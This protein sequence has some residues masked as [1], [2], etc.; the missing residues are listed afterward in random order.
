MPRSFMKFP[1]VVLALSILFSC[2]G[3]PKKPA[4]PEKTS[5]MEV[6]KGATTSDLPE[7]MATAE[8]AA[9]DRPMDLQPY[10]DKMMAEGRAGPEVA[11]PPPGPVMP[12][13]AP[14]DEV[15]AKPVEPG[16]YEE[17]PPAEPESEVDARMRALAEQKTLEMQAKEALLDYYLDRAESNLAELRYD[18]AEADVR[19]ALEIAPDD[20]RAR[21]LFMEIMAAQ[22][23]R[24]ETVGDAARTLAEAHQVRQQ[25]AQTKAN[26]YFQ[27]GVK[28]FSEERYPTAIENF[29]NVL[30]I[31]DRG[32]YGVDWGTLRS[33]TEE[34]LFRAR[35]RLATAQQ[36][37]AREA[38]RRALT[39]VREIELREREEQ[40]ARINRLLEEGL[41]AFEEDRFELAENLAEQV[42]ELEPSNARA[43]ELLEQSLRAKHR[44]TDE[45]QLASVKE[46]FRAWRLD[47]QETMIPWSER[48]LIWPSQREWDRVN[49]RSSGLTDFG[50]ATQ[51][52]PADQALKNRL[53]EETTE[54]NFPGV[55]LSEALEFLRQLH[56]LNIIVDDEVLAD[57]EGATVTMNVQGLELAS[58]LDI[59]LDWG[60]AEL[61]Y[62][63]RN[64]T[65]VITNTA[66]ARGEAVL[67][68]HPVGDLTTKLTNFIAP[69]LV[70]KPAG[71]DISDD[72]PQF[73][74]SEEGEVA[75]GGDASE[76][77]DLI[78][79]NLDPD[80][81]AD[82]SISVS[83]EDT[84]VVNHTPEM[85][86]RIA[87]FLNDLRRF[88]GLVVTIEARF[89]EVN[90][91]F[92][93][94]IGVD[95][96][97]LGGERGTLASLDDVTNGLE[98]N[99]SAGFDNQGGGTSP[100]PA[101]G[102][103]S[104]GVFFNDG[105]D[106][107]Y[108]G[109]TEGL[110]DRALGQ[111]L[112]PVGGAV[113]QFTYLDDTDVGLILKAVEKSRHARLLQAPSITVYNT[114]RANITL[115]NQLSFIQDFDVEVAQTAFIA[116]PL[117]SI[118]QDGMTL[119]VRPTISHDRRYVTLELQPTIA[120]LIRPIQT[121]T[122]SLGAGTTPV[123]LQLPETSIQKSQTTVKVPD[124]GSLVIGGL[125]NIS[126]ADLESEVPFLSKIPIL[127][128][129]FSRRGTSKEVSNLI[130]IVTARITDMH[131][132]E[133]MY[134]RPYVR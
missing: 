134:R 94:D 107:D 78:T 20:Q 106:G 127:N 128:F 1:L 104:S 54:F 52:S 31:I 21:D 62:V 83:G 111:V 64:R 33:E 11:G 59:L 7:E 22:G 40:E 15:A 103:P 36:E 56:G 125:K 30:T 23:R 93:Q 100:A 96:R 74:G 50:A 9:P 102:S 65:I 105:G 35:E 12:P 98:D 68:V 95:I 91:D 72:Q 24:G 2:G 73:G 6:A 71:A 85:Q 38:A 45:R 81:W 87:N 109:R 79:A 51:L 19:R 47:I 3:P 44:Q 60:G 58:A 115:V 84:L 82:Y 108:R 43:R 117:V 18:D 46:D 55:S 41:E 76:L 53:A 28:A 110:F 57:V 118:I 86:E 16:K 49:R 131:E 80:S 14:P 27:E 34:F 101:S 112:S 90:D 77:M 4:P 99:A 122:V 69:N 116:D 133:M 32:P 120:T 70:L 17:T 66:G 114:Q 130:V 25:E 37:A 5:E 67:R 26:Y 75:V 126:F 10:I 29:E 113:I 124:G 61:T 48:P 63:V 129:L 132:E 13:V 97:G 39:E 8:P 123:T 42:L 92:L 88:A 121:F 89:L 119:D